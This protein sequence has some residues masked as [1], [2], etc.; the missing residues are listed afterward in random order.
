MYGLVNKA[1]ED[2]IK[3]KFDDETWETIKQKAQMDIDMFVSMKTYDD[4][5]TYK[6]VGIV[7]EVIGLSQEEVLI[8]FGKY[9]VNYTAKEGYG[10]LL[11]MGGDTF[12]EFL[13]NLN[14]LHVRVG[15]TYKDL[16]PP[17]FNCEE[18]DEHTLN[19]KYLSHRE[20]LEPLV[21]G[22]LHGLADK[23]KLETQI[24]QTHYKAEHGYSEFK[25]IHYPK[26]SPE[27]DNNTLNAG[28]TS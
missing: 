17:S 2:L 9:W 15:M 21:V 23:F 5:V 13:S 26:I 7:S 10:D 18:I 20:G 6:L 3:N 1:I 22:L 4:A 28:A 19:L 12:P 25:V 11:D 16:Q 24:T 14:T 27:S 8:E